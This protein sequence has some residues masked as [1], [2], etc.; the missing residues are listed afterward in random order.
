M[1]RFE[2]IGW[3][4]TQPLVSGAP[5]E[6]T[7]FPPAGYVG[8]SPVPQPATVA[9]ASAASQIE[10]FRFH[11]RVIPMDAYPYK[12][13]VRFC[14]QALLEMICPSSRWAK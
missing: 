9:T 4:S 10:Q 6:K 12:T 13:P 14:Y 3:N 8:I 5:S 2:L 11:Q 7:T 1:I